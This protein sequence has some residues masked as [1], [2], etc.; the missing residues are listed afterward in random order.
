MK[1]ILRPTHLSSALILLWIIGLGQT[2]LS[3]REFLDAHP[4]NMGWIL[5]AAALALFW[6]ITTPIRPAYSEVL[7]LFGYGVAAC[8][9]GFSIQGVVSHSI[10][11][12]DRTTAP[13]LQTYMWLGLSAA[14]CQALGKALAVALLC[15]QVKPTNAKRLVTL[16]MAVGLGFAVMEDLVLSQQAIEKGSALIDSAFSSLFE[17]FSAGGFHV[18]SGVLIALSWM[19]RQWRWL[20]VVII[21]HTVTD[22]LGGAAAGHRVNLSLVVLELIF[23]GLT[24]FMWLIT[25]NALPRANELWAQ[26]ASTSQ[27]T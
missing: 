25:R 19:M 18:L 20:L 2:Y 26:S 6:L 22:S 8:L 12:F 3:H 16:G 14:L 1:S 24:I 21:V 23:F 4:F 15:F 7:K 17:R 11:S 10:L 27:A 9:I 5:L 13:T